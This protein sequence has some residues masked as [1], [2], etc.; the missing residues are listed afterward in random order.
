MSAFLNQNVQLCNGT[1][2]SGIAEVEPGGTTHMPWWSTGLPPLAL[3][4]LAW[5]IQLNGPSHPPCIFI[6]LQME[7]FWKVKAT[8]ELGTRWQCRWDVWLL[9]AI[10]RPW[11]P[12]GL[13]TQLQVVFVQ[14]ILSNTEGW[15]ICHYEPKK[16]RNS[17]EWDIVNGTNLV[18]ISCYVSS[19]LVEVSFISMFHYTN[20]TSLYYTILSSVPIFEPPTNEWRTIQGLFV[21]RCNKWKTHTDPCIA[22]TESYPEINAKAHRITCQKLDS[23]TWAHMQKCNAVPTYAV[24]E[25]QYL[26]KAASRISQLWGRLYF[27]TW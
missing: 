15:I 25:K 22:L 14:L 8:Q 11:E 17:W 1:S 7:L 27:Q 3:T 12:P 24:S 6:W 23:R 5:Q 20:Y 9:R 18:P 16:Y 26:L 4:L 19:H 13:A 2:M 21:N 10:T